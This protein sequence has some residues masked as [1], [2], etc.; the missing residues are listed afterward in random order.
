MVTALILVNNR[1]TQTKYEQLESHIQLNIGENESLT[2]DR[3]KANY[4][5]YLRVECRGDVYNKLKDV[6]D[7]APPD[8]LGKNVKLQCNREEIETAMYFNAYFD[9]FISK[10][11]VVEIVIAN[12]NETIDIKLWKFVDLVVLRPR[13]KMFA[14]FRL[15]F[16]VPKSLKYQKVNFNERTFTLRE[17]ERSLKRNNESYSTAQYQSIKRHKESPDP[18]VHARPSGSH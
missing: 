6:I 11:D 10:H 9:S 15:I 5:T 3:L 1:L 18:K 14:P 2:F 4:R 17:Y 13:P 7:N 12:Q 8:M 16:S